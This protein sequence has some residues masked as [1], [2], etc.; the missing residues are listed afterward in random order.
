MHIKRKPSLLLKRY[1]FISIVTDYTSM[2]ENMTGF[3]ATCVLEQEKGSSSKWSLFLPN[4][5]DMTLE[6]PYLLSI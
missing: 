3:T 2:K 5:D 1:L 6:T 4:E